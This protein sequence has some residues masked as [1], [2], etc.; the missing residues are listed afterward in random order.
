MS[1]QHA[2]FEE[3]HDGPQPTSTYQDGYT[4]PQPVSYTVNVPPVP[5]Y[6]A[7]PAQKLVMPDVQ[8]GR[9]PGPGQRLAL[10]ILS[11]IFVGLAFLIA[12]GIAA[13][14][15]GNPYPIMPVAIFFALVFAIFALAL[16]L[17]FNR[18]G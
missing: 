6:M 14:N 12:L 17:I 8:G 9:A 11:L 15:W 3:F 10:A 5:T 4:G 1:Q 2:Q 18:R 7:M 13:A 16:N